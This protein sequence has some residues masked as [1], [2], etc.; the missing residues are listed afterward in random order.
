MFSFFPFSPK[1]LVP[2]LLSN[3][4]RVERKEENEGLSIKGKKSR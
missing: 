1:F 3:L 2:F 4:E